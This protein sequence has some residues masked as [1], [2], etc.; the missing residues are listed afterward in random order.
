MLAELILGGLD[1]LGVD[2]GLAEECRL[3]DERLDES[4]SLPLYHAFPV[5]SRRLRALLYDLLT[6]RVCLGGTKEV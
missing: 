5:S 3:E 2:L 1:G 4:K 6:M